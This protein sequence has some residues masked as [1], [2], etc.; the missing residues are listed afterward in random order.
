M[1]M[2]QRRLHDHADISIEEGLA[3][4]KQEPKGRPANFH[5][6]LAIR[7]RERIHQWLFDHVLAEKRHANGP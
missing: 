2:G 3:Q 4:C 7:H 5:R 6:P 1:R